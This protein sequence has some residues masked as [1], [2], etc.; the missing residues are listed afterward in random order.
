[1]L[2]GYADDQIA[3]VGA[4]LD[5]LLAQLAKLLDGQVPPELQVSRR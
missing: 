3:E 2:G 1:M 4:E 5:A